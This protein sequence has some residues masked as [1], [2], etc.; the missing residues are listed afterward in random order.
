MY[1]HAVQ[2]LIIDTRQRRTAEA[3]AEKLA[4]RFLRDYRGLHAAQD[5]QR[6]LRLLADGGATTQPRTAMAEARGSAFTNR[7]VYESAANEFVSTCAAA[8]SHSRGR[9]HRRPGG[10]SQTTAIGWSVRFSACPMYDRRPAPKAPEFGIEPDTRQ[11]SNS[12][13]CCAARHDNRRGCSDARDK[14]TVQTTTNRQKS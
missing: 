13:T 1:P 10:N 8:Q 11:T 9:P 2:R 5:G 12:Q 4:A 14:T 3:A 7:A 6:T